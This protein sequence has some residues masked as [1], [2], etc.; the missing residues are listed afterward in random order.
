MLFKAILASQQLRKT[1]MKISRIE[2]K[3]I[4]KNTHYTG[5]KLKYPE[6]KY[7]PERDCK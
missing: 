6:L 4:W 1:G 2:L 3:K 7:N 5:L